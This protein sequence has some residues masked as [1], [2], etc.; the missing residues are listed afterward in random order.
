MYESG[1]EFSPVFVVS[2]YSILPLNVEKLNLAKVIFWVL[3]KLKRIF[4][5][6]P[7]WWEAWALIIVLEI[8]RLRGKNYFWVNGV[9]ISKEILEPLTLKHK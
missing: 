2:F 5:Y 6:H 3:T 8:L 4:W 7:Y 1:Q 9:I